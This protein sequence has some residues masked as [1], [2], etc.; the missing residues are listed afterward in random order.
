MYVGTGPVVHQTLCC[1]QHMMSM[2]G[3]FVTL[4]FLSEC[5]KCPERIYNSK[6]SD[7][8]YS[9]INLNVGMAQQFNVA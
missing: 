7:V 4:F 6:S 5:R 2:S 8:M 9:I 3:L 1:Y